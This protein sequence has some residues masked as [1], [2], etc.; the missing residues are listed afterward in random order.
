MTVLGPFTLTK[1]GRYSVGSIAGH[2]QFQ[3][4]EAVA[5][6]GA[7]STGLVANYDCNIIDFLYSWTLFLLHF[8]ALPDGE[9]AYFFFV[10]YSDG[11]ICKVERGTF[12]FSDVK[13][14][15][16]IKFSSWELIADS[17][18][19]LIAEIRL[20]KSASRLPP[21]MLRTVQISL[22]ITV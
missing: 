2:G 21:S 6:F 9:E 15:Q 20:A 13:K 1:S 16:E 11:V 18:K 12:Y 22:H 14:E 4:E 8:T 17:M 5:T 3:D 7:A 19:M 10:G